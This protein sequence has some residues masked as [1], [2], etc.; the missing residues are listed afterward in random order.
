MKSLSEELENF[1]KAIVPTDKTA[2][3]QCWKNWDALCKPLRGLGWLEETVAQMAGIYKNP[4]PT[5]DKKVVLIFGADNGVVAEGVSQTDS[6]V[7][8]QVLENMGDMRSTA[9]VMSRLANCDLIPVNIGALSEGKHPK[10]K[11]CIIRYG[12]DNIA[13]GPAMSKEDCL[14]AILKGIEIVQEMKSKGYKLIITGEMGI[15]NTTTSAACASV[16]LEKPVPAV[17]GKGAGLSTEGLKRKIAAIT[18]AIKINNPDKTDPID[19]ISKVGGLD[20]A[21]MVGCYIGAAYCQLPILIDGFISQ[22]SA[23]LAT[24]FCPTAKEYMIPTHC[25][26]EPASAL[27]M[28]KLGL[29]APIHAGMHLG[30]GTGAILA[31]SLI[32]QAINVYYNTPSWAAGKIETYTHQK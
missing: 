31:V 5:P 21:G 30:E 20:I 10:I 14:K 28:K 19:V 4:N 26:E 15:G 32:D 12:T 22:I 8:I 27:V 16:L 11:N 7:T 29:K 17:T 18:K 2:V 13:N 9:C 6:S 3:E 25:S 23:Y 24:M 1:I